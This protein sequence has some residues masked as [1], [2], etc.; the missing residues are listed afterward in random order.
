MSLGTEWKNFRLR[1]DSTRLSVW[2]L[3]ASSDEYSWADLTSSCIFNKQTIKLQKIM[4]FLTSSLALAQ[5]EYEIIL[6]LLLR[7]T[8][9]LMRGTLLSRS[10]LHLGVL[11]FWITALTQH[12]QEVIFSKIFT[13]SENFFRNFYSTW[14]FISNKSLNRLRWT[15]VA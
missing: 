1:Q 3:T 12:L 15:A 10:A 8:R 5:A 2:Y 4:T 14:S 6:T 13:S 11:R 7:N 9:M